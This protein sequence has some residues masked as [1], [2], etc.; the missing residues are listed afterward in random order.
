VDEQVDRLIHE[1][2]SVENLS[3]LFV[4]WCPFW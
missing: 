3:Q 1:A 4:G 2:M